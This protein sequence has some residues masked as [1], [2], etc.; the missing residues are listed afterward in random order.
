MSKNYGWLPASP[1][2]LSSAL[3]FSD[4]VI[5]RPK[6]GTDVPHIID[7]Q[8]QIP[9]AGLPM[10][11]NDSIADCLPAGLLHAD[12]IWRGWQ[13][14]GTYVPTDGDAVSLY[15]DVAGYVPG[16]PSTDQG[17]DAV[18]SLNWWMA[19]PLPGS[20]TTLSAWFSINPADR[21]TQALALWL[22]GTLGVGFN[23][24]YTAEQQFDRGQQWDITRSRPNY[25][26]GHWVPVVGMSSPWYSPNGTTSIVDYK[27]ATWGALQGMSQAFWNQNVQEV[28]A[29]FAEPWVSGDGIAANLIDWTTLNADIAGKWGNS[30]FVDPGTGPI[31]PPSSD[32]AVDALA[33]IQVTLANYYN[34]A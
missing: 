21:A 27:V 10:L 14:S 11:M 6:L 28:Y 3:H 15:G 1:I 23:V 33:D 20:G 31:V 19:N 25:V 12:Q 18:S 4:Y 29:M 22:G 34:P 17:S 16:V 7:W 13:D 8:G 9:S 5:K 30:P 26:G 32:R 2:Q 24:P